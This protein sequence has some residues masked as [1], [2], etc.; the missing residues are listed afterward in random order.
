MTTLQTK[1][2]MIEG[3][4]PVEIHNMDVGSMRDPLRTFTA[5]N[6]VL[7]SINDWQ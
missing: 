2:N 4:P 6:D 3:I 1:L 7:D 5:A